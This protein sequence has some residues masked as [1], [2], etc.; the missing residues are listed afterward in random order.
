[1]RD[2]I[3]TVYFFVKTK[4]KLPNIKGNSKHNYHKTLPVV[5][6]LAIII[7]ITFDRII[8]GLI[9]NTLQL[10]INNSWIPKPCSYLLSDRILVNLI[11]NKFRVGNYIS[12][13][14]LHGAYKEVD[15]RSPMFLLR[16]LTYIVTLQSREHLSLEP[17]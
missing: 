17:S 14:H 1:M 10:L 3:N 5:N 7:I 13:F 16:T 4:T 9:I 15:F 12:N 8:S 2:R 6:F 11:Y